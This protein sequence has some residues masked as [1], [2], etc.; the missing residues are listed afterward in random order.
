MTADQRHHLRFGR[1]S[2]LISA[3]RRLAGFL[4]V[5]GGSYVIDV[6]L[7]LL[8]TQLGGPAWLG[9]T[10][11]YWVSLAFNFLGNRMV[12]GAERSHLVRHGARY[13]ALLAVNYTVTVLA[14]QAADSAGLNLVAVKTV[15]VA[16]ISVW[17]YFVYK[18]W[19]F[20]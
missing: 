6:V 3:H 11:G 15:T 5:G 20:R 16:V 8:V 19:L 9:G 14:L 13:A 12:F 10:V 2:A 17:N 18:T 1:I 4:V 7:L